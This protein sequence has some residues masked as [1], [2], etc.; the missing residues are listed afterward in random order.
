MVR[1]KFRELKWYVIAD[2]YV[3]KV[4]VEPLKCLE[5]YKIKSNHLKV[6]LVDEPTVGSKRKHKQSQIHHSGGL[7][8]RQ[9]IFTGLGF[10]TIPGGKV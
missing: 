8:P 9:L 5:Q 7:Q 2:K 3:T 6:L 1:H 4:L 10:S